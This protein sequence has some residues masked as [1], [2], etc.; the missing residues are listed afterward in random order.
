MLIY[1][2]AWSSLDDAN[3]IAIDNNVSIIYLL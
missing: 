1:F 2:N 3:I